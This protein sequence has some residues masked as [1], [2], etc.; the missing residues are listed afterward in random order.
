[1]GVAKRKLQLSRSTND[2]DLG[3]DYEFEDKAKSQKDNILS[4]LLRTESDYQMAARRFI[5]DRI[6]SLRSAHKDN[7]ESIVQYIDA[8][9]RF[10]ITFTNIKQKEGV[11]DIAE[12][13]GTIDIYEEKYREKSKDQA[14][15]DDEIIEKQSAILKNREELF[16]LLKETS[17]RI[18]KEK[19][20][21][22]VTDSLVTEVI[23]KRTQE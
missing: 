9:Q 17:I 6:A 12:I 22:T 23:D 16:S 3:I 10:D 15:L 1:M 19:E 2:I 13:L 18:E 5:K 4:T 20:R 7:H 14:F 8:M 11:E 21:S